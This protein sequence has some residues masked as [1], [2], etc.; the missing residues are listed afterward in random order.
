MIA[1]NLYEHLMKNSIKIRS[2]SLKKALS[3]TDLWQ[4]FYSWIIL[5]RD[6]LLWMSIGCPIS[7]ETT[8]NN[9]LNCF[10][11]R[12]RNLFDIRKMF[13]SHELV[14]L[15]TAPDMKQT[16]NSIL[17]WFQ[18][19]IRLKPYDAAM[20]FDSFWVPLVNRNIIVSGQKLFLAYIGSRMHFMMSQS[21]QCEEEIPQFWRKTWAI[22]DDFFY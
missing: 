16:E 8:L 2:Q 12:K 14:R 9:S 20:I 3:N 22:D 4:Y 1:N 6:H 11:A 10:T 5:S 17:G 15:S 19:V 7:D 13:P 18:S 21:E